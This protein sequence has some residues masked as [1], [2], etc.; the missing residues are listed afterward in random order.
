MKL[1]RALLVSLLFLV[2]QI[3]LFGRSF[4]HP[5]FRVKNTTNLPLTILLENA[6]SDVC[7]SLSVWTRFYYTESNE[8]AVLYVFG[9]HGRV[10]F[11]PITV[12]PG[13]TRGI[14]SYFDTPFTRVYLI[15]PLERLRLLFSVFDITDEE[16]DIFK[17][18]DSFT[19]DDITFDEWGDIVLLIR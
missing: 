14:F 17:T 15:P 12:L 2:A 1:K 19:E 11:P 4:I 8:R 5:V 3:P 10:A 13:V 6:P 9:D 16:G 18:I 7:L